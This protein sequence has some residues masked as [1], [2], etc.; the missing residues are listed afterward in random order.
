MASSRAFFT[1]S[2]W[3]HVARIVTISAGEAL[4]APWRGAAARSFHLV[5]P[6]PVPTLAAVMM[7]DGPFFGPIKCWR[8]EDGRGVQNA[9][10][11]PAF[12]WNGKCLRPEDASHLPAGEVQ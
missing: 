8:Y 10:R 1:P 12:L 7:A 6:P 2:G 3:Q 4:L 9:R 5:S 11:K